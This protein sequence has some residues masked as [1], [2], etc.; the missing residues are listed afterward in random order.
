[1]FRVIPNDFFKPLASLNRVMYWE[2]ISKLFSSM[3]NQLG[4]GVERGLLVDELEFYFEQNNAA[5]PVSDEEDEKFEGGDSRAKANWML[6]RLKDYG[7]I[8]IETD[9]S[10]VQRVTF[11]D[12]AVR[13]IKVLS[14]ISDGSKVE[15]QGY[16]Y[17]IYSLLK[18]RTDNPGIVLLQVAENTDLLITGLKN[19][20]SS[21]KHYID[22]LTKHRTVS[23][24]MD[25]LFNDYI[26]NI[27]DKAYHR[28]L[29]S[30]NVAKFRPEIVASLEKKSRSKV[31]I[32]KA[33]EE[34]AEIREIS[35]EDAREQ[36]YN[37]IHY[38][39]DSFQNMDDILTEIDRKN[40]NYQKAAV[41]RARFLLTS[42]DDVRGQLRDILGR[43]AGEILEESMDLG[44]IYR[45]EYIDE[46]LRIYSSAVIDERSLYYRKEADRKFRPEKISAAPPDRKLREEKLRKMRERM[47]RVLSTEKIESYVLECLGD[48]NSMKASELP[49]NTVEDFIKLIYIRLYGQ[50][51]RLK[52]SIA[53]LGEAGD[54]VKAGGYEFRDF[55]I[56]KRS[57]DIY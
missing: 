30:D 37:L 33:A 17:T 44:G 11:R 57:G 25:A 56:R 32:S 35:V 41:N 3:T 29:T 16:I 8:D 40:T 19:L 46:L 13:I 21:I 31:Y 45:I 4:F 18:G 54:T 42:G 47:E 27:V 14:E 26:T 20:N 12:Y 23:E 24:I 10:Y 38:T 49:L 28:L 15:Y 36:V 43:L 39:V 22:E 48:R 9:N 7:W 2:C 1:M 55:E 5:E 6:R 50:R 52:Y 51:K 34:I 53:V